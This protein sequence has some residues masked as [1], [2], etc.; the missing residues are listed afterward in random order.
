MKSSSSPS[1]RQLDSADMPA[2]VEE[3]RK[4]L[5]EA[6]IVRIMKSRKQL[7]HNQ[8]VVEVTRHLQNRFSPSVALIK[9][10]IEKLIEREYLERLHN[11][12]KVYRYLVDDIFLL[13]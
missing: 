3:D 9:Q 1:G 8:L 6:L 7:E 4:H 12:W 5:T 2:S 13:H 11:D 10:R